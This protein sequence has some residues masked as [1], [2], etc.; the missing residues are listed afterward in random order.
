[1]K[2]YTKNQ[3]WQF[4]HRADTKQKCFIAEEWLRNHADM[5]K[6]VGG[7]DLWDDLME[8]IAFRCREI[9]RQERIASY[10]Y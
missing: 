3:L 9:C 10:R 6:A 8:S 7:V 5:I 4:V 1:M 2:K